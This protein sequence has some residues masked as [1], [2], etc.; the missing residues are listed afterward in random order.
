[1][2]KQI[3]L[4]FAMFIFMNMLAAGQSNNIIVTPTPFFSKIKEGEHTYA[5]ILIGHLP[6]KLVLVEVLLSRPVVNRMCLKY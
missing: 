1:M 4:C 3:I 2:M 6:S 5:L